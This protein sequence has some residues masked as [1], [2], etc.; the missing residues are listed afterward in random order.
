MVQATRTGVFDTAVISFNVT[1]PESPHVMAVRVYLGAFNGVNNVF[2]AKL[3]TSTGSQVG[4]YDDASV[5]GA[6]IKNCVYQLA[7]SPVTGSGTRTITA[8]YTQTA[9]DGHSN[10]E[11]TSIAV[12]EEGGTDVADAVFSEQG[13]TQGGA[14]VQAA[15]LS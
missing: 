8:T 3:L 11:F 2:K 14:F 10:I 7:V 12:M 5:K 1:I 13:N 6:G 4:D 15:T 9:T